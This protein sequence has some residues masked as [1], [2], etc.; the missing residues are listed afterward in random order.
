MDMM[1]YQDDTKEQGEDLGYRTLVSQ[2]QQLK[3]YILARDRLIASLSERNARLQMQIDQLTKP[4]LSW[5]D[6]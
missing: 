1:A 3:E 6:A 5:R 2:V 4:Q